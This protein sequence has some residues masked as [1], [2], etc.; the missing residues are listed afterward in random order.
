MKD[1][2]IEKIACIMGSKINALFLSITFAN[3]DYIHTTHIHMYVN[4]Y[5]YVCIY[6]MKVLLETALQTKRHSEAT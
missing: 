6:C 4:K 3:N 1:K 5:Q 2:D